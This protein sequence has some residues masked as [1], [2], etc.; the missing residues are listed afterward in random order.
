MLPSEIVRSFTRGYHELAEMEIVFD[1]P[2][3]AWL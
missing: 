1:A 2:V 3:T